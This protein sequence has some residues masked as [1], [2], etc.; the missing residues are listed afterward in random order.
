[1]LIKYVRHGM[2]VDKFHEIISFK[3]IGSFRWLEKHINFS[4]WQRN[5][6][7]FNFWKDFFKLLNNALYGKTM[8]SFRNRIKVEF[9]KKRDIERLS[10]N[11]Q[12]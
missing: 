11:S 8:E 7:V 5:Q 12:N 2:M 4:K 1:M 10:K 6:A 9:I 3:Q